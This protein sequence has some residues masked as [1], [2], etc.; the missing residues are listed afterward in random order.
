MI[1]SFPVSSSTLLKIPESSAEFP[2]MLQ[3][4]FAQGTRCKLPLTITHA[5]TQLSLFFFPI[6]QPVSGM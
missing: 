5:Y 1:Y 6:M 3:M 4:K 2:P